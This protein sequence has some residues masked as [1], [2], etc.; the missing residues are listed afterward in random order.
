[1]NLN[2]LRGL[3]A[4]PGIPMLINAVGFVTDP[5]QV[6]A[7]LG[8]PLL[9]GLGRSTQVGD[10]GSFFLSMAGFIFYGAYAVKP[11]WLKA[12]AIMLVLAALLRI[13]AYIFHGAD[14]ASLFIAVEVI[15]T[16]W[17]LVFGTLLER[18]ARSGQ[19]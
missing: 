7:T 17:L 1:M 3:A 6:S 8:M 4:V 9:E 2:L 13:L 19:P 14:F 5:A 18:H 15:L 16:I 11:A 10:F 12:A